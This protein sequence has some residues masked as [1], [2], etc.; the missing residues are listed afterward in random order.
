MSKKYVTKTF[1]FDGKR[2]YVYG[3]NEK[4][5]LFKMFQKQQDLEN[6]RVVL[7]SNMTVKEWANIAFDT[8]KPNLSESV[9][10]DTLLRV[11]KHI[12]SSIGS[13]PIKKVTSIDC[14]RILNNQK[15]MSFSHITKV[16]QELKFIFKT[17][18]QN[19]LIIDNPTENI[20]TPIVIK[21]KRKAL[22]S[23][24][25]NI[26]LKVCSNT[27]KYLIFELMY[28]CGCRPSEAIK[29]IGEDIQERNGIPILHIRGTKTANADRFVPIPKNLYLKLSKTPK[30]KP[31]APNCRGSFHSKSSYNR[32]A[33]SLKRDMNIE[34]GANTY[35]NALIGPLPLREDFVP[36]ELR[37]T[38]CTNLA[39][40]GVDI[41]IAQKLM[42]HSSIKITADIY[43]HVEEEQILD[44]AL[45]ILG[46]A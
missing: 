24:E 22:S 39:K 31:L 34:M 21:K 17:A 16:T 27:D 13:M 46:E 29:C 7:S 43:T 25:E 14:Q 15:D 37:H 32:A 33:S 30:N 12:L 6:N 4:E 44:Q 18:K 26:F 41:R 11:N 9:K 5:A 10:E 40:R 20:I 23:E 36:Y 1:R 3:N 8:Y 28:N 19:K 2:Y 45:L 42:G 38:Y 35:R